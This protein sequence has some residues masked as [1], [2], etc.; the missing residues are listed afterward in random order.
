MISCEKDELVDIQVLNKLI[1][2]SFAIEQIILI[3]TDLFS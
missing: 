3:Y 2:I 1:F